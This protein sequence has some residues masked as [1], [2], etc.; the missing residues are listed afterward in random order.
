MPKLN[1]SGV[2]ALDILDGMIMVYFPSIKDRQSDCKLISHLVQAC[3]LP[4]YYI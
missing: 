1:S 2:V 4:F 3:K